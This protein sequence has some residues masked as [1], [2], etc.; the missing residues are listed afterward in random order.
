MIERVQQTVPYSVQAADILR[1]RILGGEYQLGQRLS[2]VELSTSLG[3]SRSP[4]REALRALA[5]EGLVNLV[6]G[7][8]VFVSDFS[9]EQVR[10]LLEV[11]EALDVVAIRLAAERADDDQLAMLE[12][13]LQGLTSALRSHGAQV[14]DWPSDFHLCIYEAAGNQQLKEHGLSV[15][16]QLRLVRFRSGAA[17]DRMEQAHQEHVDMLAAIRAHEPDEA[18]R[19]MRDHLAKGGRRIL[20]QLKAS[21]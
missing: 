6:S 2:E 7:R 20:E 1:S 19:R 4:L 11:R 12:R 5:N 8:G 17:Q 15:H 9:F 16:T 13:N 3:I 10:E 18:E 14:Q 21:V